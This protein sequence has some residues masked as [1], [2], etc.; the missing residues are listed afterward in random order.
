MKKKLL[1][2]LAGILLLNIMVVPG[3]AQNGH[4]H[5][6]PGMEHSMMSMKMR[7]AQGPSCMA[8]STSL[9]GRLDMMTCMLTGKMPMQPGKMHTMMKRVFFLDRIE[10]LG[11]QKAQ[12]ERL[13]EIQAAC[14][15][16][17]LRTAAEVKIARLEL[18]DLLEGDWTLD[19]AEQLIRKISKFEGDM[20]VRHLA[21]VREAFAVLTDEQTKKLF[22]EDSP[23][24]LF[25]E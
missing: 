12:V 4:G 5:R 21:A 1:Y 13:K 17:N 10:E 23:E 3:F 22:T 2:A 7:G 9:A 14:R 18:E 24:S 16:D 8:N 6:G 20:K 15:R 25:D 11:L 19:A